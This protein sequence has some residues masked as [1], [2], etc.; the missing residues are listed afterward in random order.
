MMIQMMLFVQVMFVCQVGCNLILQTIVQFQKIFD[1]H[2]KGG[3]FKCVKGKEAK[4]EFLE[5]SGSKQETYDI[6]SNNT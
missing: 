1:T 5:G 2:P 6:S 4:L 3:R